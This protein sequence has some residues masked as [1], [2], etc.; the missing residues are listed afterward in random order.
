MF[1]SGFTFGF[2]L[3]DVTTQVTGFLSNPVIIGLIATGLALNAVYWIVRVVK[4][5]NYAGWDQWSSDLSDEL[6]GRDPFASD[7]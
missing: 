7:D 3:S 1:G 5:I 6:H 2:T 4:D